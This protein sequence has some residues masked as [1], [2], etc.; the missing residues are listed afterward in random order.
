MGGDASTNSIEDERAAVFPTIL[1]EK[2][3]R[4]GKDFEVYQDSRAEETTELAASESTDVHAEGGEVLNTFTA[5][6]VKESVDEDLGWD[7]DLL[8]ES[9]AWVSNVSHYQDTPLQRYNA[10]VPPEKQLRVG[11]YIKQ[12]NQKAG[13][14]EAMMSALKQDLR[15][16]IVV[17]RPHVYTKTIVKGGQSMGLALVFGPGSASIIIETVK[18]GVVKQLCPEVR[19]GDRITKVNGQRGTSDSFLQTMKASESVDIEFSRCG[20]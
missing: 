4:P 16:E 17:Q 13:S 9:R 3:L 18:D 12:V 15:L 2:V 11:D 14:V 5:I 20:P 19:S 8:A 6:L 10:S 1:A 7:L